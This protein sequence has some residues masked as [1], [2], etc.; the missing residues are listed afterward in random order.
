MN[1]QNIPEPDLDKILKQ[2]LKDDLPP[3]AEAGMNRQ[4]LNFK[5]TLDPIERLAEPDGWLG[6]R[7]SLQRK[8]LAVASAVMLILGVVMHLSG[9]QNA[10][11]HSIEQ[12]KVITTVSMSLN[13]T[14]YMDCTVSNPGAVGEHSSY[15]VRW[16]ASGDA[17]MDRVSAGRAQTIWI[18]NET[19]SF[20][21]SDGGAVRSM[22]IKT[23]PPG[24]AWQPALE[25]M[26]PMLL[27]KHM[28]EQYGLMQPGDRSNTGSGEFLIVGREDQQAIEITI[29]SRTYLPK[30]LKKYALDSSRTNGDHICLMEV[31]FHWN[32][33]LR[34]ELFVP[35]PLA[36][37]Q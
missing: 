22:P 25:F 27:A 37:K 6:I 30:V 3:E 16:L 19:I 36:G 8:I 31:Q 18:S 15:H 23:M 13:R 17:R 20:A 34:D 4:F 7:G 2:A 35:G 9:S 1:K 29:D 11:A 12:L 5:R 24:S 14:A 26:T 33:P 21:D 28:K 10:L 32:Q